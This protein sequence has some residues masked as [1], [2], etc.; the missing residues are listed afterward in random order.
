MLLDTKDREAASTVRIC[1]TRTAYVIT[2]QQENTSMKK[3][4]RIETKPFTKW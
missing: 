1:Y 2:F 3:Y 4:T